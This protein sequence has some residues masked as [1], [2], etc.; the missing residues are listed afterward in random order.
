MHSISS[1]TSSLP[2]SVGASHRLCRDSLSGPHTSKLSGAEG[3]VEEGMQR[4]VQEVF[5]SQK[6]I[7]H[8]GAAVTKQISGG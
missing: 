3:W 5:H 1:S 4:G 7:Y 8:A 2:T 6:N